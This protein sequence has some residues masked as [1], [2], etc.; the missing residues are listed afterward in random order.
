MKSALEFQS[1]PNSSN[2]KPLQNP[3]LNTPSTS[4]S[5]QFR[6][7]DDNHNTT[8]EKITP[9]SRVLEKKE[10][11]NSKIKDIKL[12]PVVSVST[13]DEEESSDEI[14]K[15]WLNNIQLHFNTK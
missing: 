2:Y 14:V 3:A 7:K 4:K 9:K 11:L 6:S 5:S 15:V 1:I 13:E 10:N 8:K 12:N